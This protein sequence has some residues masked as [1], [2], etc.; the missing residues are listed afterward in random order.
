MIN[1]QN[2]DDNE[3]FKWCLVRYLHPPDDNPRRIRKVDK[4]FAREPDLN[5][6]KFPV[7]IRDIHKIEKKNCIGIGAFGYENK[8][9]YPIYVSR[10][11]FNRPV[12]INRRKRQN[13]LCPYQR[14]LAHLGMN[15]HYIVE[16]NIF[17]VIVYK[18]LAQKKY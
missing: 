14:F 11:T 18:L 12:I 7:K 6:I 13:A 17:V 8:V 10:N 3:C 5:D 16:E 9:K 4:K 1:I 15:I 2:I